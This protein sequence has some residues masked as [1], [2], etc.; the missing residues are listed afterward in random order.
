VLGALIFLSAG[1]LVLAYCLAVLIQ[2]SWRRHFE[3]NY[4]RSLRMMWFPPASDELAR[5]TIL[6]SFI[7]GAVFAAGAVV[8][9]AGAIVA[10]L[11]NG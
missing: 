7:G 1:S 3:K 6:A 5:F 9:G 10:H 11:V 4:Q 8:L 2:P